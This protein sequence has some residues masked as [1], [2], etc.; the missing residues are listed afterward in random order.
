MVLSSNRQCHF[1][2]TMV[3]V[4]PDCDHLLVPIFTYVYLLVTNLLCTVLLTCY[5]RQYCLGDVRRADIHWER[6]CLK[7]VYRKIPNISPG[8][9]EIR[10]PFLG[11]L[12]SV[13]LIFEG[14]GLYSEAILY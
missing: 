13:G 12:Y 2:T 4:K 7:Q 14:G 9:I 6:V 10:K 1:V 8:L 5:R 3:L 11:G